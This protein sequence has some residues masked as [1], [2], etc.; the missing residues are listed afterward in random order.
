M[1]VSIARMGAD[2]GA[3]M[4]KM[5]GAVHQGR[6]DTI[7]AAAVV[8]KRHHVDVIKRDTG[9]DMRLSGVGKR[10][11]RVGARFD[12]DQ[13]AATMRATGPLHLR[14]R[15]TSAHRIPKARKRGGQRWVVFGQDQ[16]RRSV[17][18]PGTRGV[19]TWTK[20][21]ERARPHIDRTV[22]D[23]MANIVRRAFR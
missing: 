10:G 5:Q 18:H 3:R 16:V 20:G 2:I 4:V 6:T 1:A 14:E 23:E 13:A 8:A 22:S 11:A 7:R 21:A 17:M 15:D 19:K 9:G 12:I